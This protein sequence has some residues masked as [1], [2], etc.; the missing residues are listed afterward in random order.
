MPQTLTFPGVYIEEVPSGVRP[1]TGVAT[2]ITAFVGRALRGPVDEAI[3]ITSYADF[4]RIFGGLW[5]ESSLGYAVQDFYRNGG[6]MAIIVRVHKAKANDTARDPLGSRRAQLDLV[7]ASP[8]AWGSKL[9]ATIDDDVS[10]PTDTS[11]FNL[12]VTDTGTGKIESFRN[13]SF[14]PASARRVDL[15]LGRSRRLVRVTGRCRRQPQSSF[16]RRRPRPTATTATRSTTPSSPAARSARARRACS[17]SR[18]P[19]SSTCS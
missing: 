5:L 11:L 16:P 10:D 17:R 8:G 15:V 6:S 9:T 13:V 7:A 18:R 12:T 19:T 14:A 4:E 1:I 3:A 2:S